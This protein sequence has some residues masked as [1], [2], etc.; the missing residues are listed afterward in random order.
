MNYEGEPGRERH[1]EAREAFADNNVPGAEG[2]AEG[3]R[4]R[5]ARS[6]DEAREAEARGDARAADVLQRSADI[7]DARAIEAGRR[8]EAERNWLVD[9][10]RAGRNWEACRQLGQECAEL[11]AEVLDSNASSGWR[12]SED[13]AIEP[14]LRRKSLKYIVLMQLWTDLAVLAELGEELKSKADAGES[15][16]SAPDSWSADRRRYGLA[17][18]R[19]EMLGRLVR[20]QEGHAEPAG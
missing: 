6:R 18:Y 8:A 15:L 5:A 11:G 1:D 3:F 10:W 13:A 19:A 17:G 9:G 2:S 7:E 12:S 4:D 14:E 16:A 20:E